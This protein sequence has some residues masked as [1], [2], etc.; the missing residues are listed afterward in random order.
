MESDA[1]NT[2][3]RLRLMPRPPDAFASARDWLRDIAG[4]DVA[5]GLHRD[6]RGRPRLAHGLGDV[7]WSHSGDALLL[8]WVPTGVVGVDI[9]AKARPVPALRIARRYFAADET[10]ALAALADAAR[11]AAFLRLWCAKEAVLKAHG[12]GI[13]FGLHKAVF[14]ATGDGLRML[15]CDPALG[16]VDDWQLDLLEPEPAFIAVLASTA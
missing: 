14:D 16:R 9:E 4:A 11:D 5:R 3:L 12:G 6:P 13:A 15:R 1:S 8:A 7:G 10:M 2:D